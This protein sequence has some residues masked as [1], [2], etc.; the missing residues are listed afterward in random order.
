MWEEC[1]NTTS[2]LAMLRSMLVESNVEAMWKPKLGLVLLIDDIW[3]CTYAY[4]ITH[5][6]LAIHNMQHNHPSGYDRALTWTATPR[7]TL[8]DNHPSHSTHSTNIISTWL[9]LL[10]HTW[11]HGNNSNEHVWAKNDTH[12]PYH[13]CNTSGLI[14][15]HVWLP[16]INKLIDTWKERNI[17]W[18]PEMPWSGVHIC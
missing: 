7:G 4:W 3:L 5:Q 11:N 8:V 6:E 1:A 16:I 15:S 10:Q 12:A 18:W 14:V 9:Y 17:Q 2:L 13:H